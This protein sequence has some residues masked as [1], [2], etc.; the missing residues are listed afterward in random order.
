MAATRALFVH[1]PLGFGLGIIPSLTDI[2]VAKTG[3]SAINYQPDNG[4]VERYMFGTQFE[5]HS[6][7]G[8]LWALF[9]IPGTGPGGSGSH[10]G[11]PNRGRRDNPRRS[12]RI[13][14]FPVGRHAVEPFLQPP[15]HFRSDDGA[16]RGADTAD[17]ESTADTERRWADPRCSLEYDPDG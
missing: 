10:L 2:T 5:V 1:D 8:D 11:D 7:T 15:P 17:K 4:Y 14:S 9:G 13:A 12:G 6:V 3:M 16:V